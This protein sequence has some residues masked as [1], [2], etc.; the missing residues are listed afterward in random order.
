METEKKECAG[1]YIWNIYLEI[2]RCG[3]KEG[4]EKARKNLRRSS[5]VVMAMLSFIWHEFCGCDDCQ[6]IIE[7]FIHKTS[8]LCCEMKSMRPDRKKISCPA[9][10]IIDR[11]KDFIENEP[12]KENKD[13]VLSLKCAIPVLECLMRCFAEVYCQCE[14]CK[15]LCFG[16]ILRDSTIPFSVH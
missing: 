12:G 11:L 6:S 2:I 9:E 13:Y 10:F 7:E 8:T 4:N 14:K 3:A 16:L 5:H 1:R 15:N